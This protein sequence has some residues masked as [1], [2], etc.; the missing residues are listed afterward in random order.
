MLHTLYVEES[1]HSHYLRWYYEKDDI[2]V[3]QRRVYLEINKM[4]RGKPR[5]R[6]TQ[7]LVEELS[8]GK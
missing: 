7:I 5:K 3:P 4:K 6:E 8:L 2:K 1:P